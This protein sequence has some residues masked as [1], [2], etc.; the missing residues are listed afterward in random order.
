MVWLLDDTTEEE[1]IARTFSRCLHR[2]YHYFYYIYYGSSLSYKQHKR[3]K[4]HV[5]AQLNA[6]APT[7]FKQ[8]AIKGATT[9]YV[10]YILR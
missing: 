8:Q 7:T 4:K 5:S 9:E 1:A 6:N 3:T 2:V 10:F